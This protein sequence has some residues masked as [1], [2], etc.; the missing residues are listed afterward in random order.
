MR[1]CFSEGLLGDYDLYAWLDS[2]TDLPPGIR[3]SFCALYVV[4][5]PRKVWIWVELLVLAEESQVVGQASRRVLQHREMLTR[6]WLS[7]EAWALAD[8]QHYQL[9]PGNSSSKKRS[10]FFSSHRRHLE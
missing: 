1:H 9:D 5:G 6:M 3:E 7:L 8:L 4:S 2:P 10:Y